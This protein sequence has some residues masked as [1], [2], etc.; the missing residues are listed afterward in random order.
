MKAGLLLDSRDGQTYKIVTIGTQTWMAQNLNYETANSYCYD[1]DPSNCIK[2]GRLYT[3]AAAMNACP[4]GWHLPSISERNPLFTAVG[5]YSVAGSMLKSANGWLNG[6]NGA[7]AYS[8]TALPA[9]GRNEGGSYVGEGLQANFWSSTGTEGR[10]ADYVFFESE[11][12]NSGKGDAS[13]NNA[14]SVRCVKDDASSDETSSSSVNASSSSKKVE[15]SSSVKS[16]SSWS[17]AIGSMTDSRDGQVYKTVTIGTQTWMAQNL[18][19][20][21]MNSHCYNDSAEYCSKYGRLYTWAAAMDSA[22]LWSSDGKGCGYGSKCSWMYPV[23]G[24]CPEGWHLPSLDEWGVLFAAVGGD[25]VAGKMLK[26]TSG[27]YNNGNG[28]D[29]FSFSLM[30]AG[31]RTYNGYFN[32]EGEEAGFWLSEYDSEFANYLFLHYSLDDFGHGGEGKLFGFSVRC[33]KDE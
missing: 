24:V 32:N 9:G 15:L 26:S 18:N 20:K 23:R 19:Y 11:T 28:T 10:D 8:F 29:D 27:W 30:P 12:D 13:G 31:F 17:G 1:D 4:D 2:Y 3:W 6:G 14:F 33:V 16:S 25:D 21:S 7:D 22:G 5:G